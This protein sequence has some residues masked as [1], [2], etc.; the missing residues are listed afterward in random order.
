M[1]PLGPGKRPRSVAWRGST[2]AVPNHHLNLGALVAKEL[3]TRAPMN[4]STPV[5]PEERPIPDDEWMEE[6]THLARLRSLAAIPLTLSAQW[7]GTA[8]TN[9][10]CVHHAQAPVSFSTM[11]MGTK[12]LACWTPQRSIGLETKVLA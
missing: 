6:N 7:A 12:R 2:C 5:S 1:G 11:F 9:T 10:G 8:T 4:S 3:H